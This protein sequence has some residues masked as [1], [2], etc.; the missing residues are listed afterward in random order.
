MPKTYK[1]CEQ[2][3]HSVAEH[4]SEESL[5]I[6]CKQCQCKNLKIYV[7]PAER[8]RLI[9]IRTAFYNLPVVKWAIVSNIN[10]DST[11]KIKRELAFLTK[12]FYFPR[13]VMRYSNCYR[14]DYL[15]Q[16][17]DTINLINSPFTNIY[18]SL[19]H[20]SYIP[21]TSFNLSIRTK[22]EEYEQYQEDFTKYMVGYNP[23]FDF[24]FNKDEGIT[25]LKQVHSQA[26]EFKAMLDERK[27]P[28]SL[29]FSGTK[30]FHF[31]MPFDKIDWGIKDIPAFVDCIHKLI[32]NIHWAF[33][34]KAI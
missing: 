16:N 11:N 5:K 2:C 30:G 32:H 1:S 27:I 9:K 26:K 34:Y 23:L 12:P 14:I 7:S 6:E 24:D 25:T 8:D 3:L 22:E 21:P 13:K 31:E 18:Y 4:Y 10:L 20:L 28:Y 29:R 15:E 33:D 19:A 17:F